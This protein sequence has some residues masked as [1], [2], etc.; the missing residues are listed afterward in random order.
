MEGSDDFCGLHIYHPSAESLIAW[1]AENREPKDALGKERNC[2]ILLFF[3]FIYFYFM[4]LG[5]LPECMCTSF[6]ICASGGQ[7][8]GMVPL[9]LEL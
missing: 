2:K 5:I 8:W 4:C 1:K 3:R 7:K 9:E 6:V